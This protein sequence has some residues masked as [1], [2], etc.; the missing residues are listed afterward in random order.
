MLDFLIFRNAESIKH[1][2]ET[3]RSKQ[4]HQIILKGN[5]ELGFARISLTAGTA[6]QL[7][8]NTSGFMTLCTDDLQATGFSCHIIKL[9]IRTTACHVGC[10]GNRSVHT[11]IGNNFCFQLMELGIQYLM[12]N[13]LLRKHT[14]KLLRCLNRNCTNQYRLLLCMGFLYGFHNG[15]ELFFSGFIYGIL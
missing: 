8:I 6:S 12:R 14:G 2:D 10:N 5:I 7:I 3:L 4:T 11:G 9:N 1:A 15:M 13:A